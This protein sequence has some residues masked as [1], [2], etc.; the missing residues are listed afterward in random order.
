[1]WTVNR[2]NNCRPMYSANNNVS[3]FFDIL[4][5]HELLNLIN[6]SREIRGVLTVCYTGCRNCQN[7]YHGSP[8]KNP[9][10]HKVTKRI[11]N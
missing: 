9:S 5:Y 10:K 11:Y 2:C 6:K 7:L 8:G 4:L 1:M 3:L